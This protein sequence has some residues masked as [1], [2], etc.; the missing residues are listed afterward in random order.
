MLY[1]LDASIYVF[2]AWFTAPDVR[3][4]EGQDMGAAFGYGETLCQLL[5]RLKPDYFAVAFD[6]SLGTCWRNE[7][8]SDYKSNRE[9]APPELAR[10]FAWCRAFTRALGVAEFAS[11]DHE[12]DDLL[13]A[14]AAAG[15][16][17]GHAVTVISRDKDLGQ[18]LRNDNDRLWP[19]P[20]EKPLDHAGF[21]R[22]Y[23]ARPTQ[24]AD[25]LALTGDAVDN[26]PGVAGIGPRTARVLLERFDTLEALYANIDQVETLP[27]RGARRAARLL[28]EQRDQAFLSRRLAMLDPMALPATLTADALRYRGPQR[29]ELEPLAARLGDAARLK[30]AV[31]R[32]EPVAA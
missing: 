26:I 1:L 11:H 20:G 17:S 22:R 15:R 32:L 30:R 2:R 21:T 8:Y 5:T 24:L 19:F 27:L 25:F 13:A 16:R 6:E 12:A 7:I 9:P 28:A 18:L 29:A 14:L 4:A 10:Q 23:G 31:R 3:D